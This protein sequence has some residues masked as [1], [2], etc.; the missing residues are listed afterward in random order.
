MRLPIVP[1]RW[2]LHMTG[3]KVTSQQISLYGSHSGGQRKEHKIL[4]IWEIKN[5]E[6]IQRLRWYKNQSDLPSKDWAEPKERVRVILLQAEQEQAQETP[7]KSKRTWSGVRILLYRQECSVDLVVRAQESPVHR[8][9]NTGAR[10]GS[11]PGLKVE[12]CP[13]GSLCPWGAQAPANIFHA[14]ETDKRKLR[15]ESWNVGKKYKW[16]RGEG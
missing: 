10:A 4:S 9:Q 2:G 6:E 16:L 8:A 5:W 12:S 15:S 14:Y 7:S 13:W 11:G 1:K 3:K